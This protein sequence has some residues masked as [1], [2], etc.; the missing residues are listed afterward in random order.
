MAIPVESVP[1]AASLAVMS[2]HCSTKGNEPALD[3]TVSTGAI[4]IADATHPEKKRFSTTTA[5][6]GHCQCRDRPERRKK[7]CLLP[8]VHQS[9]RYKGI[10]SR[11]QWLEG[12]AVFLICGLFR[13]RLR[14]ATGGA[15]SFAASFSSS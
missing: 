1:I 3:T 11:S 10:N 13:N 12:A 5:V 14:L 7:Q 6:N 9:G 8:L 2:V 15:F 4:S